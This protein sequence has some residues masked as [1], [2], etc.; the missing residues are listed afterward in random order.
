MS[1][2]AFTA[3]YFNPISVSELKSKYSCKVRTMDFI[4]F[5]HTG[6]LGE[7]VIHECN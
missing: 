6:L 2:N 5:R 3:V 1:T 4:S 7:M